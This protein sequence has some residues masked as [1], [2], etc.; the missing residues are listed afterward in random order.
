MAALVYKMIKRKKKTGAANAFI[1]RKIRDRGKF[2][3]YGQ[4][5]GERLARTPRAF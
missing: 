5:H 1:H 2:S 3:M 4:E